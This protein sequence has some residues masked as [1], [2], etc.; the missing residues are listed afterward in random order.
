MSKEELCHCSKCGAPAK[1]RYS[2]PF[3][4][5]ECKKKCGQRSENFVDYEE[6]RDSAAREAA[7]EDWNILNKE[8]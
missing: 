7:I 8:K 5:V 3:T 6:E 1:I 4:W 2:Q